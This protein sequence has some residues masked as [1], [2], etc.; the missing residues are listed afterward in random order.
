MN[1]RCKE[2]KHIFIC[3][4]TLVEFSC[5]HNMNNIKFIKKLSGEK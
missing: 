3:L 2:G 1:K 5:G 4:Q